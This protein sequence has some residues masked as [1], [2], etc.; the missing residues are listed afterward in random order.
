MSEIIAHAEFGKRL[1]A[2]ELAI[3]LVGM[4]NV[5]KSYWSRRLA[6]EGGFAHV[7]CDDLIEVELR[8]ILEE[9]G[10]RGGIADIAKWLDQPYGSQFAQN[11]QRYLDFEIAAMQNIV[12]QLEQGSPNGNTVVD[13]TG[14]V[15]HTNQQIC[16]RL[17]ALTTVVYLEATP[18]MQREMF[19]LYIAEPKPVVWGDIYHPKADESPEQ[20]LARCY[21]KLL[22]YRS[23]LYAEMSHVTISRETSLGMTGISGFLEHVRDSL[24]KSATS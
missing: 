17:G 7:C 16:E 10:Y 18:N 22:A 1:E 12:N 4:S 24:P 23:G 9:L 19:E 8:G 13:T 20:A 6:Q 3:T 15:V 2:G 11:Q 21:P 14:S 5:G